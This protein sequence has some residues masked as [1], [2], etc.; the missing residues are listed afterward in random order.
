MEI[1]LARRGGKRFW[2]PK[3]VKV[4]DPLLLLA[5]AVALPIQS[6]CVHLVH[7]RNVRMYILSKKVSKI[8]VV[9]AISTF[10]RNNSDSAVDA[11]S[12]CAHWRSAPSPFPR[13]ASIYTMCVTTQFV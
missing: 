9:C 13:S 4:V 5:A 10:D 3:V 2:Q 12:L 8:S 11:A 1:P 7:N 6:R